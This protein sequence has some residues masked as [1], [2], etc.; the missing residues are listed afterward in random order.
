MANPAIASDSDLAD[1]VLGVDAS[2][3]GKMWRGRLDDERLALAL[4]Q[5]LDVPDLLGRVLAA[6]GV[7]LDDAT[8]FLEP[9]LRALLPDP[10]LLRDM[11]VAAT[12]LADAVASDEL[13]AIFGD[14]DVDGATASALVRL[15]LEAVGARTRP[16]IPDRIAEGYGPNIPAFRTLRSE[17]AAV[18]VTVD[19]GIAAHETIAAANADGLDVLVVDH[20]LTG[21]DLP[22]AVASV[23]P[24]RLDDT[25]GQGA[26]AAVG[27]AFV[28]LVAVNRTLRA[29]GWF[30]TRDEPDLRQ[31]LDLVALGTVCDMVPLVGLNRAFVRQGLKI[32]ARRGNPGIAALIDVARIEE[33]PG[34][35][36]AGFLL[37]PRI[38][39]G[40]RV[41]AADL[42]HRLLT[43]RSIAEALPLAQ[44]LDGLNEERKAIETRMLD[45]ALRSVE[46]LEGPLPPLLVLTGETWHPGVIGLIASRMVERFARPT[47][48]IAFDGE[49]GKGSARSVAGFDFGTAVTAARQSGLIEGGGGHAMAA[50]LT[51]ERDRLAALTDFLEDRVRRAT[52]IPERPSLGVDGVLEVGG[53]SPSLCVSVARA[54]PFG[55]GNSEPR[56][57]FPA[58][59]IEYA[60]S[61][62]N[63][64]VSCRLAG[65]GGGRLK[66]IAFRSADRPVGAALLAA[67]GR[68]LHVCGR[69][70]ADHWQGRNGVQLV[71][72]D[73]A[74]LG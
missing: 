27:V 49:T 7:G 61:V 60:K 56:F 26:L 9:T 6:R 36:E 70:R 62:G 74:E 73:V 38:N 47:L 55:N 57:A 71:I 64:H 66:A 51:V 42:G 1:A 67:G 22:P 15:Y 5:S 44:R 40:G 68:P 46:T 3:G 48:A 54:G 18:V 10:S 65:A 24:N 28:L 59:R 16:Y 32:L 58:C 30:E 34:T 20:H 17:G 69:L 39:A 37:G 14:Y 8:V 29:R 19:C 12:R 45:E 2:I 35:Y 43:S 13:I 50:G 23:N 21:P 25:S 52:D 11:D 53:A 33:T 31:W 72:D 63:G 41:G 4:S